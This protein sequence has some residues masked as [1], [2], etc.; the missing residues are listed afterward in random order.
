MQAYLNKGKELIKLLLNNGYEA[1]FVGEI[2]RNIIIGVKYKRADIITN[3]N[4]ETIKRIFK[5]PTINI[6]EGDIE[7]EDENSLKVTYLEYDYYF[8]QFVCNDSN[9]ISE[10]RIAFTKHY[11]KNLSDDLA[12]KNFTINAIAMSYSGKLTDVDE[13]CKDVVNR[14]I[15]TVGSPKQKFITYPIEILNALVIASELKFKIT[16]KTFTMMKKKAKLLEE[17]SIEKITKALRALLEYD[18]A[19]YGLRLLVKANI[20]KHIPSLSKGIYKL[21]C[22]Y[23]RISF[24]ELLLMNFVL[25]KQIDERYLEFVDNIVTFKKIFNVACDF[26]KGKYSDIVLFTQGLD[27][28]LEANFINYIIGK[29]K[30]RT[31]AIKKAY[32]SLP[33]KNR[34]S[35]KY[36]EAD[37]ARIADI[38]DA[39]IINDILNSACK[40]V[41]S[42]EIRNDFNEIQTV[43]L[44]ALT[45]RGILYD[46]ERKAPV[47]PIVS[48]DNEEDE[49]LK[50]TFNTD[51][52]K[53]FYEANYND[54]SNDLTDDEQSISNQI[55]QNINEEDFTN[56][57]LRMLEE[58]LDQQDR[59]LK[60]KNERLKELEYQKV[61]ET[62]SKVVNNTMELIK[63]DS[64]VNSMI[65]DA[66]DFELH[67]RSFIVG[68]LERDKND[69]EN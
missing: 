61:L 18:Y 54:R 16:D 62:T 57:R 24:D 64:Q 22:K 68:Y 3:A 38:N 20:H 45:E 50:K 41:L 39:N 21:S 19:K 33:I 26:P 31:K 35:L 32:E 69:E 55:N 43:V 10:N 4:F 11:S 52:D 51:Y 42:G 1:Y 56:H 5:A 46:L 13:G 47:K 23:R 28:C 60:E 40:K 48:V 15:R 44:K 29:S 37:I 59:M 12:T 25:N 7:L 14:K 6:F 34:Q 65:D 58:R 63:K 30:L 49:V 9:F 27:I 36:T 53:N 66:N 67:L 2:V 8:H 17:E